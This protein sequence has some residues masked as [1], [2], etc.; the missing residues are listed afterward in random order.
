MKSEDLILSVGQFLD[1][2]TDVVIGSVEVSAFIDEEMI[3]T[4]D[5]LTVV[6]FNFH[7]YNTYLLNNIRVLKDIADSLSDEESFMIHTLAKK[8][9][10][11]LE[12]SLIIT[13]SNFVWEPRFKSLENKLLVLDK[14]YEYCK[15][16]RYDYL[17]ITI[18]KDEKKPDTK[19]NIAEFPKI[20]QYEAMGYTNIIS[21]QTP[22]MI[23]KIS[24]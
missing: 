17:M 11:L 14:F 6:D 7:L 20:K 13:L 1:E 22:V 9:Q 16:M 10:I 3:F 15:Y 19:T 23:K 12:N 4:E 24:E 18:E 21:H 8:K 2:E 5:P